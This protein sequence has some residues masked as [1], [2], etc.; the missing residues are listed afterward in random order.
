MNYRLLL[1]PA[2]RRQLRSL[3][4]AVQR[5]L[6]PPIDNLAENPRPAGVRVLSGRPGLYR[7]RVGDYRIIY[8]VL[9]EESL[10]L[11]V[12][13]GHRREVYRQIDH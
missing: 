10:I 8:Q 1:R 2:A 7:I 9:D 13:I 11:V 12:T 3:S 5:R 6:S 4:Q